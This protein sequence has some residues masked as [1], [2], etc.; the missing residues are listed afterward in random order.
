M[1][2]FAPHHFNWV[3]DRFRAVWTPKIDDFRSGSRPDLKT[4]QSHSQTYLT[5]EGSSHEDPADQ[6]ARSA[7]ARWGFK[8]WGLSDL[9]KNQSFWGSGR[10][11]A[12]QKPFKVVGG[13]APL[14]F[15]WVPGPPGA[16]QNPKTTDFPSNH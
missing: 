14:P 4:K 15:E 13:L 7:A 12:A 16:A 10:P 3:L 9:M 6:P 5:L 1:G 11:R 2:H 8:G